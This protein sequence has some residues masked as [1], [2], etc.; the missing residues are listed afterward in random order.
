MIKIKLKIEEG[1][2]ENNTTMCTFMMMGCT[3]GIIYVNFRIN[4]ANSGNDV[5]AGIIC[6]IQLENECL[7]I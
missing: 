2:R 4:S 7:I 5:F 6:K 3:M 1:K